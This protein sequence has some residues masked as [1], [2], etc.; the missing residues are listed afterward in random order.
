VRLYHF[1][2]HAKGPKGHRPSASA[3][4]P[5][6]VIR[7]RVTLSGLPA[8]KTRSGIAVAS[9]VPMVPKMTLSGKPC[10]VR[11]ASVAPL[12]LAA[13]SSSRRSSSVHIFRVAGV[14]LLLLFLAQQ[15]ENSLTVR[16]VRHLRADG[17]DRDAHSQ[18]VRP[19]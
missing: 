17:E 16:F 8:A 15:F 18:Q 9:L 19:Q 11:S 1:T 5:A 7:T 10:A 4:R 3:R 12:S 6:S 14:F 13:S 2:A